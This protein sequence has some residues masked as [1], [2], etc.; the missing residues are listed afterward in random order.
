[1]Y[2]SAE[3]EDLDGDGQSELIICYQTPKGLESEIFRYDAGS[4]R[5]L[6][7]HA[8]IILR[9]IPDPFRDNKLIL[10]GQRTDLSDMFS[11]KMI[12]FRVDRKQIA[13]VGELDLPPGTLLLSYTSGKMGR[14]AQSLRIILNQDQ[15]LMVF[16][17]DNRLLYSNMERLFGLS[18]SVRLS[19]NDSPKTVVFP[20]R[21]LLVDTDGDGENELL[22]IKQ[23]GQGSYIQDFIWD[24]INLVA[25]WN[26]VESQ[27]IITDFRVR[28]FKNDGTKSLV[29]LL[30]KHNPLLAFFGG[31]RSVVFAYDLAN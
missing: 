1:M 23:T 20:G 2:L 31:P 12:R 28:D 14:D 22:T 29:L 6:G 13:P 15:R 27:G 24:G 8:N 9:A 3:V 10:V 21:L 5:S 7:K 4:L 18:R 30:V 11:G 17:L 25:K 26:S 16:D 19:N